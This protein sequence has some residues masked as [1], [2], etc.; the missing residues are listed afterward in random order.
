MHSR[1]KL[2]FKDKEMRH[3]IRLLYIIGDVHAMLN[4]STS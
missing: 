4:N 1:L 3:R 2:N